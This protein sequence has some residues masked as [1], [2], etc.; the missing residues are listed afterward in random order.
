MRIYIEYS[1]S[2]IGWPRFGNE[3]LMPTGWSIFLT[4]YW[5]K[6]LVQSINCKELTVTWSTKR[7]RESHHHEALKEKGSFYSKIASSHSHMNQMGREAAVAAS[8]PSDIWFTFVFV[9]YLGANIS[10][11]TFTASILL[12]SYVSDLTPQGLES[13]TSEL[14]SNMLRQRLLEGMEWVNSWTW[15]SHF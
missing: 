2:K 7:C 14:Q 6:C 8:L 11:W 12:L 5:N 15:F 4:N 10:P 13:C 3:V 1:G 9:W